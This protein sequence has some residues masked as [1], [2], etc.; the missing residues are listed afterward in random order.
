MNIAISIDMNGRICGATPMKHW[1]HAHFAVHVLDLGY[2]KD[3]SN[4]KKS[5]LLL[6]DAVKHLEMAQEDSRVYICQ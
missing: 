3:T 5:F 6:V 2:A 1:C 4:Q